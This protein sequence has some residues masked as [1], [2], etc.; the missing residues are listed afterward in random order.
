MSHYTFREKVFKNL[1]L[2]TEATDSYPIQEVKNFLT[3]INEPTSV[4]VHQDILSIVPSSV[5][6]RFTSQIF[7]QEIFSPSIILQTQDID[8][9]KLKKEVKSQQSKS[10]TE[11]SEGI[12]GDDDYYMSLKRKSS[13]TH[14]NDNQKIQRIL[15]DDEEPFD[16]EALDTSDESSY[17]CPSTSKM[18]VRLKPSLTRK[19]I[20]E[21]TIFVSKKVMSRINSQCI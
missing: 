4:V 21:K 12:F 11:V 18:S 3:K 14:E 16:D 5:K 8:E 7:L 15:S 9:L 6:N 1:K 20:Q 19:K 17:D 13:T 2:S 10:I